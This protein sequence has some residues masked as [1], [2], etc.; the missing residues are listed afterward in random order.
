VLAGLLSLSLL[1]PAAPGPSL[2]RGAEYV[3]AGTVT[4]AIDRP[5]TRFRRSQ[6]LEVRVLVLEKLPGRADAAVLT[7]LRGAD[8]DRNPPAARLDLVRIHEDGTT[9]LLLPTGP[10]PLRLAPDTPARALPPPPLDTFAAVE[11]GPFPPRGRANQDTW[12]AA[13]HG[14]PDVTWQTGGFGFVSGERCAELRAVQKS[15]TWDRPQG[16]VTAWERTETVWTSTQDG[17]AR[18]VHRVVR[19]RDGL[20]TNDA[21]RVETKYELRTQ[22]RLLGPT[23]ARYRTEVEAAYAAGA[24]A[25]P[26][27]REAVRLGPQPFAV[28][29][30]RLDEFLADTAPG[31]PYREAALTVRRRLDAA[32]RGEAL[33][34]AAIAPAAGTAPAPRAEVG[35]PAPDF[36]AGEFRLSA[37]RG[38]AAV[39]V[40]FMPGQETA[41]LSLCVADALAKRYPGRVAVAPLAVFAAPALAA[42]DIERRRLTLAV[43]DGSSA[44]DLY[45]IDTY[46]RF[47]VVDRDGVV[48]WSFAG[49]GPETGYLVREQVDAL[50]SPPTAT[51]SPADPAPP[52][53]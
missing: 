5:G 19:H 15:A 42:K 40:F 43:H 24:E 36:R 17:S 4:E 45:G 21:V 6:Q 14:R 22:T 7:L 46:P 47:V 23:Y 25:E 53:R 13:E 11:L 16:A 52:P 26:L 39:L 51:A 3:Y 38:K 10:V 33:P 41:E 32:R 2:E 31:T 30:A 29:L 48:R 12:T 8:A 27:L 44:V 37:A 20:G 34:T 9:H 1:A 18:R 50:L 49:V 28:R 35:R